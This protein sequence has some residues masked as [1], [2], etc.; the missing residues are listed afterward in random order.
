LPEPRPASGITMQ[1]ML[2]AMVLA[3]QLGRSIGRREASPL[4]RTEGRA[5]EDARA[6]RWRRSAE[7]WGEAA[8]LT[9]DAHGPL[10]HQAKSLARAGDHDSAVA[11][12]RRMIELY[13]RQCWA[14]MGCVHALIESSPRDARDLIETALPR[15]GRRFAVLDALAA[16][17]LALN[18][19]EAAQDTFSE[20][21]ERFPESPAGQWGWARLALAR[22]D[23]SSAMRELRSLGLDRGD[24]SALIQAIELSTYLGRR[25]EADGFIKALAAAD[26]GG[27]IY[28]RELIAFLGKRYD[29]TGLEALLQRNRTQIFETPSL[30]TKMVTAL[31]LAGRSAQALELLQEAAAKGH[32][33][34]RNQLL[35]TYLF[36]GQPAAALR[37][38][39]ERPKV[40]SLT[41]ST[42]T[43]LAAAAYETDQSLA[44][45]IV[46]SG[47]SANNP[48]ALRLAAMFQS[49]RFESL[50]ALS[51]NPPRLARGEP[52]ESRLARLLPKLSPDA[53][54]QNDISVIAGYCR[55]ISTLRD[56]RDVAPDPSFVAVDAIRVA[57]AIASAVREQRAFSLVRL[58]DGEGNLLPYRPYLAGYQT[59]DYATTQRVWWGHDDA[60]G[61]DL[62]AQLRNAI[63]GADI[64]GIPD[65]FRLSSLLAFDTL[66]GTGGRSRNLRGLAAA[67]DYGETIEGALITSCHVHQAL[68]HWGLWDILLPQLGSVSIITCHPQL[69]AALKAQYGLDVSSTHLIPP[70]HKHAGQFV[71]TPAG[72]HYPDVFESLREPLSR[73][74][75]GHVVL[76][77]AGLLGKVYCDWIKVAG[78]IAIDVGSAADHWC[79][80][81]TRSLHETLAYQTPRGVRSRIEELAKTDP[82]VASIVHMRG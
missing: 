61:H 76:V 34:F 21:T 41:A 32:G 69:T 39:A 72:R 51:A 68:G 63:G 60:T 59:S 17:E 55:R 22:H 45:S 37:T 47:A 4:I 11:V 31:N 23:W 52:L 7:R 3:N 62:Q 81:T 49:A 43:A 26:A 64:V 24:V 71:E 54:L 20:L 30:M 44:P 33:P 5:R 38:F 14:V 1:L 70:E 8:T 58:G 10:R 77:A 9:A 56:Q 18:D 80:Y 42:F 15:F 35:S 75:R 29:F 57:S 6:K 46:E 73:V 66:Q 53:D 19:L 82:L 28:L 13:P 48:N 2:A 27:D 78:G 50:A 40:G 25:N 36:L 65:L 74:P 79:G 16:A 67:F 12:H